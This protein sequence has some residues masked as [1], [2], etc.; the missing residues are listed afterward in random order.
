LKENVNKEIGFV[1]SNTIQQLERQEDDAIA[2]LNNVDQLTSAN[3]KNKR[4]RKERT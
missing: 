2:H 4:I 1:T 3:K